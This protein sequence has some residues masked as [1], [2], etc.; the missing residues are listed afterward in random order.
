MPRPQRIEYEHAFYHVM[1]RG[2]AR[3]KI[4][5]DEH[6]YQVFLETLSEAHQRF[7]GIIHAYCLMGNHYHLL[8]ETPDAN[9]GRIMRHINGVYTQRHNRLKKTDGPLFRGRYK[10]VLVDKDAYLLQLSRY[11]HRNPIDT[12]RPLVSDLASYPW[13][14]YPAYINKTKAPAWLHQEKIYQLLGHRQCHK[15]Y[16]N[17]VMQGVDD[18]ILRYY[19][20]GN[21]TSILGEKDFRAWVYDNLLPEL[22]AEE[23]GPIIQSDIS[24]E[25]IVKGVADWFQTKPAELTCVIKGPQK[26]NEGRKIAMY[27]CQEMAHVKLKDIAAYFNLGHIGSVSFVTHQIRKKKKEDIQLARTMDAVIA[28]II[29]RA[30]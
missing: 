13:S 10:A 19:Q 26:G 4:F 14:S 9:L 15:A 20:R 6:F 24:M 1:N 28:S 7:H 12:K 27:L 2:R 3:Q 23:K 5:H 29:K 21:Q 11:I 25:L 16:I 22:E 17:Y 8:L 30:N 18:D